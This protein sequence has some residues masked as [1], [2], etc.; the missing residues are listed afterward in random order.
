MRNNVVI[1][2]GGASGIEAA[3]QLYY[4]GYT[5]ILIEKES[6]L[7]GHLAKWDRL[8]PEGLSARSVLEELLDST[9]GV[10]WFVN[11]RID[12]V[13]K[14][15]ESYNIIL[16]NGITINADAILITTGFDLFPSEKKEEYGYGIY[17]RVITN[18]DLESWFKDEDDVRIDDPQKIGF[19]HCVGSRDEKVGNRYCSKVCCATAVK[20]AIEI[21]EKF[22]KADVFCFYMDLRMF[23]RGYEDLYLQAQSESG[24][25]F[26]RGRVSE[27]SED[28]NGKLVIKAEDT[29][30]GKPLRLSL[31]LLVLMSGMVNSRGSEKLATMLSIPLMDDGFFKS[32]DT[33]TSLNQSTKEGI[34]FAGA[35]T[36][37]KTLPE[38][39]SEAR[40]AA[41]SIHSFMQNR[42]E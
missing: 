22:P 11:T 37:P 13:N 31:D 1:I 28:H 23:G 36:G 7:G 26:V 19:V 17:E 4:L 25:R 12:S 10:K 42:K 29:L 30:S 21:K 9:G 3:K 24:I 20:Q 41:L 2:G 39:L 33:I 8:F 5:P 40:A 34:F 27:V 38:S 6:V 32:R 35:C 15:K 14:L 16:S 18:A